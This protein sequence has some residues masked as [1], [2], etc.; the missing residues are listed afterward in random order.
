[1]KTSRVCPAF[2]PGLL[3]A[4]AV[5]LFSPAASAEQ[6]DGTLVTPENTVAADTQTETA[7]AL[8]Q[9]G[10]WEAAFA[11]LR[12]R[13]V[14]DPQARSLLFETG[15]AA[16]G[17]AHDPALAEAERGA[18]LDISIAAFRAILAADPE[19]LR[20]RL[21]LARA[22]F[23][24]RQDWLAKRQFERVLAGSPPDAVSAN[25]NRFLT[26]IRARRRWVAYGGFALA[27]DTNIG[28]A[29]AQEAREI[30]TPFGRFPFTPDDKPTSGVGVAVWA[31][32]EY[33]APLGETMRLRVGGDISRR[34]YKGSRFDTMTLGGHIGPR[35]LIGQ[36]TEASLLALARRR[37]QASETS[38]DELGFRLE[39]QHNPGPRT[40]LTFSASVRDRTWKAAADRDRDGPVVGFTFGTRYQATSNLLLNAVFL[41]ERDRPDRASL[42]NRSYGL[43]LG[44]SQDL[45]RGFTLGLNG[46]LSW[47][48]YEERGFVTTDD[49]RRGDRT[50]SLSLDL[51]KRD[52]T[53]GGLSP[54][55]TIGHT[56]RNTNAVF[57]D[58]KRTFGEISFVRQF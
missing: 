5:L 51:T 31:G 28:A 16:L 27:P 45:P 44:A 57:Q 40:L 8:L 56:W 53:I 30:N 34:E 18:L 24:K 2:A 50:S 33:Q 49:K 4:L 22:F 38:Y 25:V 52:L 1:M 7:G 42:R 3:A 13:T 39:G 6:Q 48:Q 46:S 37:W 29:P 20:V 32:W 10:E 41:W 47:A 35:W 55:L 26:E 54:R 21:E 9:Q 11:I 14:Q 23:L 36:R 17:A 43:T 19:L 12:S 58:Y 15:I